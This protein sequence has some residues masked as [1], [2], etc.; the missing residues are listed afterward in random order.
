MN[1]Q[2]KKM[3]YDIRGEKCKDKH[4]KTKITKKKK[5]TLVESLPNYFVSFVPY[6]IFI[7][8]SL[9]QL[10]LLIVVVTVNNIVYKEDSEH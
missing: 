2:R 9:F 4:Y 10:F 7:R 6:L 5:K 1:R 3:W 8:A